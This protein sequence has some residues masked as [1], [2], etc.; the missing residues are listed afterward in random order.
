MLIEVRPGTAELELAIVAQTAFWMGEP[1]AAAVEVIQ[2]VPLRRRADEVGA[3]RALARDQDGNGWRRN[4]SISPPRIRATG[5]LEGATR[6]RADAS[7]FRV[8]AVLACAVLPPLAS[9]DLNDHHDDDGCSVSSSGTGKRE[10]VAGPLRVRE[11]TQ[12]LA[13]PS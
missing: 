4:L 6:S 2:L 10:P 13:G 3:A 9:L 7:G 11:R 1:P 5:G 8:C 12:E